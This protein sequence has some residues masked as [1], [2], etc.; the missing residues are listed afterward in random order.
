MNWQ[1]RY[2][3]N[4]NPIVNQQNRCRDNRNQE[5]YFDTGYEA[6]FKGKIHLHGSRYFVIGNGHL[7]AVVKMK[8]WHLKNK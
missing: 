8:I 6:C 5:D 3:G 4:R 7:P 2:R 1:N